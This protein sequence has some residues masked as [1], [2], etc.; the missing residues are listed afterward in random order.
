MKSQLVSVIIPVYNREK[1]IDDAI[2]SILNQTYQNFELIIVNDGS[3]DETLKKIEAYNDDRIS[4]YSFNKN[5][6]TSAAFNFG[7]QKSRGEFIARLDSDDI[8]F[9][10]RLEKQIDVL[11][12][13]K[14]DICCTWLSYGRKQKI[15]N[16]S[17]STEQIQA[18]LLLHCPLSIGTIVSKRKV[19]QDFPLNEQLRFGEDYDFF[20]K[21]LFHFTAYVVP[22]VLVKYRWHLDQLSVQNKEMQLLKDSQ[23]KL[24]LFKQ[25][26]Y[27]TNRFED[28]MTLRLLK[29]DCFYKNKEISFFMS[30]LKVIV[31]LN[32][33]LNIYQ[34]KELGRVMGE[35]KSHLIQ[36]IIYSTKSEVGSLRKLILLLK[37]DPSFLIK[38]VYSKIALG[39]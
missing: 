37:Y 13:K 6:G 29:K 36:C 11:T 23:I 34:S 16:Y 30:W 33:H 20:S 12:T 10:Q 26:G 2:R 3:T 15:L 21:A 1:F 5:R 38:K 19:F 4:I 22:E 18:N 24:N 32:K 9:E 8:A 17:T 14:I 7:V 28:N 27:D 31:E 25:F 35:Y 39:L